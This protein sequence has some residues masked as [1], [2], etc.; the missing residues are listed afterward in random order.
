V[1]GS[2]LFGN[3]WKNSRYTNNSDGTV[4]D[5]KT[6]LMWKRCSEGLSGD[7]CLNVTGD[8]THT[9]N[10]AIGLAT[11]STFADYTDWRLPNIKELAS[12]VAYDNNPNPIVA[13]DHNPNPPAINSTLF[14]NTPKDP[15]DKFWS[16]TFIYTASNRSWSMSFS[17]G[18]VD[19]NTR[20][21]R[22]HV[23]LVRG[24]E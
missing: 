3:S 1:R 6:A 17:N 13:Y 5:T 23:R 20:D 18:N 4:T 16:S 12:L 24:G 21:Y 10:D 19:R 15:D 7:G 2:K 9:Y 22:H 14:P 8:A 11:D